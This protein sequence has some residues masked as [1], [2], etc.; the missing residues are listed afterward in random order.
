MFYS[1]DSVNLWECLYRKTSL[2]MWENFHSRKV[3]HSERERKIHMRRNFFKKHSL[4]TTE[5]IQAI[6]KAFLRMVLEVRKALPKI[7]PFSLRNCNCWGVR[8]GG[9][10][11]TV[12]FLLFLR[13]AASKAFLAPKEAAPP[14][15][16]SPIAFP[17]AISAGIKAA[18]VRSPPFLSC[19]SSSSSS[20]SSHDTVV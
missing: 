14:R 5:K 4:F 13:V 10:F 16:P 17:P 20:F 7:G 9:L 15:A 11:M 8:G 18:K 19:V 2:S 12:V 1:A 3:C 6:P